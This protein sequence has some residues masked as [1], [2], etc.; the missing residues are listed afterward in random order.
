MFK[1]LLYNTGR[2][3]GAR[4]PGHFTGSYFIIWQLM[5]CNQWFFFVCVCVIIVVSIVN[6][7]ALC[8]VFKG[9]TLYHYVILYLQVCMVQLEFLFSLFC[10][11][12]N[13]LDL[14]FMVSLLYYVNTLQIIYV[15]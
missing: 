11:N 2:L 4:Y 7:F 12:V 15:L 13:L 14:P 5:L 6:G 9:L 8:T 3:Y 1:S 10:D